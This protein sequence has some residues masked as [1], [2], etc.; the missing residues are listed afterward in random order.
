MKRDIKIIFRP[1]SK[2]KLFL[3]PKTKNQVSDDSGPRYPTLKSGWNGI[4][5]V[6]QMQQGNSPAGWPDA[7]APIENSQLLMIH[8]HCRVFSRL[9]NGS[10]GQ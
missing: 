6:C 4:F 3:C 10:E 1:S 7:L 8:T 2:F 5:F 9:S